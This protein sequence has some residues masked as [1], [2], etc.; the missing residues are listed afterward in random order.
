MYLHLR[1]SKNVTRSVPCE[2]KPVDVSHPVYRSGTCSN[3]FKIRAFAQHT[4]GSYEK[5]SDSML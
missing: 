1:R 5:Y 4:H 3:A 2:P